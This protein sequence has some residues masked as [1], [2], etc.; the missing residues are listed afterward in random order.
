M[1]TVNNVEMRTEPCDK[2]KYP[3]TIDDKELFSSE[4]F[5]ISGDVEIINHKTRTGTIFKSETKEP[6][7]HL[8]AVKFVSDNVLPLNVNDPV[9]E[10]LT[11]IADHLNC[12]ILNPE[13]FNGRY[14][15]IG[16]D[17]KDKPG[18][19]YFSVSGI[20]LAAF[21]VTVDLKPSPLKDEHI[22]ML[23]DQL[24]NLDILDSLT[25]SENK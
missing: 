16:L 4:V 8:K 13:A 7:I 25:V 23:I 17:E 1:I 5:I 2:F 11:E 19:S 21:Y 3:V 12:F 22:K 10:K 15:F 24:P 18:S 20:Q 14:V 9:P 6:A